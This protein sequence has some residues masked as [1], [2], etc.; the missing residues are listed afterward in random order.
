[1]VADSQNSDTITLSERKQDEC[2]KYDDDKVSIITPESIAYGLSM[3]LQ[4]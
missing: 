2:I 3:D 4:S 1:M